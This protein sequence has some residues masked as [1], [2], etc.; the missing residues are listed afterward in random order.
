MPIAPGTRLGPYEVVSAL[1]AGGMGEV[2]RARDTR[3]GRDVA[4]KIL[5]KE[6]SG[7]AARKQRFEREAK[8]I[9]SLNHPHIC[10][11][12]DV[13][14][15]D[16]IDYLVMECI[17]GEPL[18]KRLEKGALPLEQALKYGA[19]IAD[20][21]DK[22]HRSGV[23]HRDL[24][25]G[26]VMLTSTGAKLLDFGLAKP[27]VATGLATLTAAAPVHSPVT[28]EG[29]I[30]GT[31]Q[32]MSPEQ[33]E[34]KEV[35]ARSDIFSFG[36]LLYE[37]VTG[38]Q[39]F[40]G[41]TQVSVAA[42]ILERN[43]Q[44]ITSLVPLVPP[45]LDRVVRLCLAKARDERWQSAHDLRMQLGWIAE[46]GETEAT[47]AGTS[48]MASTRER[49]AWGIAA[50]L[51]IV[52]LALA[53]LHVRSAPPA[54][55]VV[56]SSL[57]PP[58]ENSFTPYNFALSADGTRLAFVA[59]G[60]DGL[61]HLWVRVLSASS[62]QEISGTEDAIYPFW[63]PDSRRLG[64]FAEGKLKTV[65][66]TGGGV[67][68]LC[69]AP[70]GRGGTW[71]QD[72]TIVFAPSIAVP[73]N[74]IPE[75]GGEPV[76]LSRALS[77]GSGHGYR[78]PY[79]LPD[80]KHFVY[81]SDWSTPEDP[82][83]NGIY[84]GSLDGGPPKLLSPELTGNVEYSAGRLLYVRDR[85]LMAQPFDT[86]RLD[87]SGPAA[88]IADQ[89]VIQD[90]A[91]FYHAGFSVS[92]NGIVV[93]QS[94]TAFATRLLWYDG[95]GKE[96][97][98]VPGEG[99]WWPRLSP[100]GRL[101]TVAADDAR[102]GRYYIHV[103][104]LESGRST[105][106]SDGGREG[107]PVWSSDGKRIAYVGREGNS[108]A[109]YE[110]P[111][112]GSGAPKLLVKGAQKLVNDWSPDGRIV[113]MDEGRG[114]P[115]LGVYSESDHKGSEIGIGAEARVSPDGKWITLV[116]PRFTRYQEIFAQPSSGSGGRIQISQGGGA[117][118]IWKRDGR[119]IYYLGPD[120]KLMST[121]F[122]P[123]KKTAGTP[124]V[125]FQTHIVGATFVLFQY[126]VA[127]DGRFLVNTLKP[128]SPLTLINNWPTMIGK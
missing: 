45:A 74:R 3:L 102:N 20:A 47:T 27:T 111:I 116:E 44:P 122:D 12:Y 9:S 104:D 88:I 76:P 24:K 84:V 51:A 117:Q 86:E 85:S 91:G 71:N 66:T 55:Q 80:G 112:D 25:P 75:A 95:K 36:T 42:A 61:N 15:S 83:G 21:L 87:F 52:A 98:Q 68:M 49:A 30:V 37:M 82:Q 18:A 69:E 126:D 81:F 35:D 100:D 96:I 54:V 50:L 119:E 11:L 103:I 59:V 65:D 90:T 120:R 4:I 41:K 127:P 64:F 110:I 101:L 73:L 7:D 108:T 93:I 78:W 1:G 17:E 113:Y 32:Y 19:E 31:F 118:A 46:S 89:E 8:T 114:L 79:F 72:G 5:P 70:L 121:T 107:T 124:R 10:V 63:A 26:N 13:G 77:Q 57:L 39:A 43:P 23:V 48:R 125:L 2:Y 105:R 99:Y 60:P 40:E 56:R 128:D 16:G 33:V 29:T 58:A 106:L 123:V 62:A 6:V 94:S 115:F 109:L 14:H 92:Q 34:G 38:R 28:Q 67:K 22:A 53:F 97:G